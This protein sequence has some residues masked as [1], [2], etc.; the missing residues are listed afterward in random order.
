MAKIPTILSTAG[1]NAGSTGPQASPSSFGTDI[2]GLQRGLLAAGQAAEK[3]GDNQ[4]SMQMKLAQ[5]D[6]MRQTNEAESYLRDKTTKFL[7]DPNNQADEAAQDRYK[8]MMDKESKNLVSQAKGKETALRIQNLAGDITSRGYDHLVANSAAL[9][10]GRT[11]VSI[12]EN[13]Q[14]NLQAGGADHE[15][16]IVRSFQQI[17]AAFGNKPL[18]AAALKEQIVRN[19]VLS[20][21]SSNPARAQNI[22]DT[23][24]EVDGP[25][26]HSL[27]NVIDT[28]LNMRN[29]LEVENLD[30]HVRDVILGVKIANDPP[31]PDA[32]PGKDPQLTEANF[33]RVYGKKEGPVKYQRMVQDWNA[34]S[35]A[36]AYW[37]KIASLPPA[38]QIE[39]VGSI[40]G[41][42]PHAAFKSLVQNTSPDGNEGRLK[43]VSILQQ[44]AGESAQYLN[45]QGPVAWLKRYNPGVA[46]LEAVKR[47]AG[48]EWTQEEQSGYNKALIELQTGDKAGSLRHTNPS[49]LDRNEATSWVSQINQAKNPDEVLNI[50]D[51]LSR[52]FPTPEQMSIG[53]RDLDSVPDTKIAGN[54]RFLIQNRDQDWIRGYADAISNYK[55]NLGAVPKDDTAKKNFETGLIAATQPWSDAFGRLRTQDAQ[56]LR[57]AVRVYATYLMAGPDHMAYDKALKQ[58]ANSLAGSTLRPASVNGAPFAVHKNTPASAESTLSR[59]LRSIDTDQVDTT[60]FLRFVSKLTPDDQAQK[61]FDGISTQ[62]RFEMTSDGTA[63]ILVMQDLG[64]AF[65]AVRDTKGKPF[66]IAFDDLKAID[67]SYHSAEARS[68]PGLGASAPGVVMPTFIPK[69]DYTLKS[70]KSNFHVRP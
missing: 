11:S 13:N 33:I 28:S 70:P 38:E 65:F 3:I 17:D 63:L 23:A 30:N 19:S 47:S 66:Q 51:G 44:K 6:E 50:V 5:L 37:Q 12:I 21:A 32:G 49:L 27:Q 8:E 41:N 39:A 15:T 20:F 31:P 29:G 42:N 58:A 35:T 43:I 18:A 22:L 7:Q 48:A 57:E 60:N 56:D 52:Q 34:Y 16:H 67:A 36:N 1:L 53:L 45:S 46:A 4:F 25:T 55:N 69:V 14:I 10:A 64:G 54:W 9:K 59:L 40:L 68:A 62:G 2:S 26:R 24:K 61:L